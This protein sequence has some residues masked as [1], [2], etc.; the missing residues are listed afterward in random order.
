MGGV[1]VSNLI[2]LTY[3]YEFCCV[4]NETAF[5]KQP[6]KAI[7]HDLI[8]AADIL[9][10]VGEKEVDCLRELAKCKELINWVKQEIESKKN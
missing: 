2:L 5:K 4:Q 10:N 9:I 1:G 8:K 6:L 7:N 3:F